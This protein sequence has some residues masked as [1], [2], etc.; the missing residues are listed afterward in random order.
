MTFSRLLNYK[1]TLII[2]DAE[3]PRLCAQLPW[4]TDRSH[5]GTMGQ[6]IYFREKKLM[7]DICGHHTND[8][9]KTVSSVSIRSH[10]ITS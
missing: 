1:V 5:M 10:Y 6:F 8:W 3:V 9:F 7:L 2:P 4:D